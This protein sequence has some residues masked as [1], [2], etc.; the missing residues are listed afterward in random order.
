MHQRK[1][2]RGYITFSPRTSNAQK[3]IGQRTHRLLRRI[4]IL[5]PKE[6][7]SGDE[8]G[9][10]SSYKLRSLASRIRGIGRALTAEE[11][12]GM[13]KMSRITI[14]RRAKRGSIPS[15]R[16][17]SCVRFDPAAISKWLLGQGVQSMSARN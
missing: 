13:L 12:A 15:F 6:L 2:R 1:V 17:G 4:L 11:L 5:F 3:C 16:V 10:Q 7:Q 14:L 8:V 9:H